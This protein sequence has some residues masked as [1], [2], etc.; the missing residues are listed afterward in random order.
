MDW[1]L[2]GLADTSSAYHCGCF[3]HANP[4]DWRLG[5]I[6]SLCWLPCQFLINPCVFTSSGAWTASVGLTNGPTYGG[7]IP[8]LGRLDTRWHVFVSLRSENTVLVLV[9]AIVMSHFVLN[10]D[11]L[12]APSVCCRLGRIIDADRN[13]VNHREKSQGLARFPAHCQP[14]HVHLPICCSESVAH[15]RLIR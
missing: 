1:G 7:S 13:K 11:C 5:S 9:N 12:L 10:G 4:C 2:W 3:P 8:H 15:L 6:K 14:G